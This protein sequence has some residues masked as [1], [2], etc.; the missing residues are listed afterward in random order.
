MGFF[1]G[2]LLSAYFFNHLPNG[3]ILNCFIAFWGPFWGPACL[4][5]W[6]HLLFVS[7]EE[8]E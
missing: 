8:R 4:T 6:Q 2:D 7:M 1:F 3:K 5:V